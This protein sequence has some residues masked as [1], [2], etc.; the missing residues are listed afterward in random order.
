LID[1]IT[2]RTPSVLYIVLR[3]RLKPV[4]DN[5]WESMK[6]QANSNPRIKTIRLNSRQICFWYYLK[7]TNNIRNYIEFLISAKSI[8]DEIEH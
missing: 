1:R 2:D 5:I 4:T 6:R 8:H 7:T 3:N